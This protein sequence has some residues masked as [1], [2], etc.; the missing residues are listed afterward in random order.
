MPAKLCGM[1]WPAPVTVQK[2]C[3][4]RKLEMAGKSENDKQILIVRLD[5]HDVVFAHTIESKPTPDSKMRWEYYYR[6]NAQGDLALA[7]KA[8][9][10]YAITDV[11]NEVLQKVTCET[12]GETAGD[13]GKMLAITPGVK[14]QFETEKKFW[15][16]QEKSLNKQ[17]HDAGP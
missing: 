8:T 11:D 10:R 2:K 9:F 5:T 3:A 7:L 4:V 16:K 17:A 13:D 14:A 12:Y 15:L 1:L 6:A